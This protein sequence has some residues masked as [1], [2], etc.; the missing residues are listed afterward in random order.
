VSAHKRFA[1]LAVFATFCA[2]VF[3]AD[4]PAAAASPASVEVPPTLDSAA[5][6]EQ[7]RALRKRADEGDAEAMYEF[8]R[9]LAGVRSGTIK[10]DPEHFAELRKLGGYGTVSS[11]LF[12]AAEGGHQP[13]ID[14]VCRVAEDR[15][16]PQ[17]LRDE[18]AARCTDLRKKFPAP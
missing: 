6:L 15:L 3:A 14:A 9:L 4:P 5:V 10:T 16:A 11:W 18:G 12:K 7:G 17:S 1:W 8:G 13:A 2:P